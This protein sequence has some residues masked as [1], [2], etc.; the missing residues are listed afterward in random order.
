MSV[1]NTDG[2]GKASISHLILMVS[3]KM[4]IKTYEG[5]D[6]SISLATVRFGY[7][8]RSEKKFKN[9]VFENLRSNRSP[10]AVSMTCTKF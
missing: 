5:A 3:V 1:N 7:S 6:E 8:S 9:L 4:E 10:M 2:T